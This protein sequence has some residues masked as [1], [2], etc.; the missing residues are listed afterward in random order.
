MAAWSESLAAIAGSVSTVSTKKR[1][2]IFRDEIPPI[3]TNSGKFSSCLVAE[4]MVRNCVSLVAEK[5]V[6]NE[7]KLIPNNI[8]EAI[9]PPE[10]RASIWEEIWA[11]EKSGTWEISELLKGKKLVGCKWIFTVKC[12][13]NGIVDRFKARLVAKGFT[14]SYGVDYHETFAPNAK[15]N[16]NSSSVII[17]NQLRLTSSLARHQV[18]L[19]ECDLEE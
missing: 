11:L 9:K 4:T 1:V 2:R 18:C 15:L 12:K 19:F 8:Q 17:G 6:R 14:Q 13:E 5:M 7:L 10:W 3:L 16:T